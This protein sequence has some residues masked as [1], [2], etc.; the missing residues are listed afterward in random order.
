[1]KRTKDNIKV[2]FAGRYSADTLLSGPE[3]TARSIFAEHCLSNSSVFIQYFFDGRK[4]SLFKKLFGKEVIAS[5]GCEVLTLGLLRLMPELLRRKPEIIHLITFERFA[6]IFY[7][8]RMVFNVKIIYNSHGIVQHE[9]SEFKDIPAF[10]RFKDKICEK[11]FLKYSDKV[12][13]PSIL[14]MDIAEKYCSVN[15][16]KAV[17]L[18]NGVNDVFFTGK[19]KQ[20]SGAKLKAV[21][22]FRNRLNS[23]GI[24][25]LEKS[26]SSIKIPL[27]IY[28]LTNENIYLQ[29]KDNISYHITKLIPSYELPDFYADKDIFLSLNKYDTF[30]ISTAEAMASGLIPV[31]TSQTGIS[32][33]IENGVNGFVFDHF[34]IGGLP[35]ILN[36]IGLT[37]LQERNELICSAVKTAGDLRWSSVYKLYEELY[38][39]TAG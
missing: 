39:E 25:L 29:N 26:G 10:Y 5:E 24:E 19:A 32:R 12:I 4:F 27:D 2:L 33:Y 30:S 31:V 18:P 20:G 14:A 3:R 16:K 28:I 22:Q 7:I 17:V 9:N 21:L 34:D 8:Y 6:A 11:I 35:E 15:E 38:R 23:S 1:M 37:S 13:F 36:K